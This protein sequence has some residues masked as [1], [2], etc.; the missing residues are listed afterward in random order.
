MIRA[1]PIPSI[2]S[3]ARPK[4]SGFKTSNQ[5]FRP[6]CRNARMRPTGRIRNSE[7]RKEVDPK[8]PTAR[9]RHR[10]CSLRRQSPITKPSTM[11]R[12]MRS[13]VVKTAMGASTTSHAHCNQNVNLQ[14]FAGG[15][16]DTRT[17][18]AAIG[19]RNASRN[20]SGNLLSAP[21]I[22]SMRLNLA[23]PGLSMRKAKVIPV[24]N[25]KTAGGMRPKT[26]R[27]YRVPCPQVVW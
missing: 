12:R 20:S 21:V 13:R 26:A 15:A 23:A 8:H 14:Q 25:R 7:I 5:N 24:K 22:R 6:P 4:S 27:G 19:N 11:H 9:S 1:I 16:V 10:S 3:I 18:K 17:R 2:Q